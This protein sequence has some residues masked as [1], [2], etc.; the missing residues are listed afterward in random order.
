MAHRDSRFSAT[1][2]ALQRERIEGLVSHF[3]L[4]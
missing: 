4:A 2:N 1:E 3:G